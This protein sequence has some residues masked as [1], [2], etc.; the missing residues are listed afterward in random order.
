EVLPRLHLAILRLETLRARLTQGASTAQ[1]HAEMAR[2]ATG[3]AAADVSQHGQD[4]PVGGVALL[5][6]EGAE[7]SGGQIDAPATDALPALASDV[8]VVTQSLSHAHHDLAALMRAA[9][10]ASPRRMEH[11]FVGALRGSLDGEFRG[12]FDALDWETPAAAVAAADALPP[13]V[14]DLLLSATLEAVRNAGRHARGGDLHRPL[15]LQVRLATGAHWVTVE[16][17]DDGVGL[18]RAQPAAETGEAGQD[19]ADITKIQDAGSMTE[20]TAGARSGLLTHGA[21]VAL[22]G[23]SLTVHSE[24]GAGATVTIRAPRAVAQ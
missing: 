11:G 21:L 13:I 8:G 19:G 10:M 14:A 9:P 2:L 12:V 5:A 17:T 23:G 15:K 18:Q 16:V 6:P 1:G 20:A 24:P 3:V 4:A 22:I 7:E